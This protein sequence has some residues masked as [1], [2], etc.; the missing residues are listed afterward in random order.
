MSDAHDK[1]QELENHLRGGSA[2]SQHYDAAS[3]E[4]PSTELD[5]RIL[6]A[7]RRAVRAGPAPLPV[8]KKPMRWPIPLATAAIVVLSATVILRLAEQV[9]QPPVATSNVAP[10]AVEARR[11]AEQI[12]PAAGMDDRKNRLD[13]K[14]PRLQEEKKTVVTVPAAPPQN[15]AGSL[16]Q[17][18]RDQSPSKD[19][20]P[21]QQ[22]RQELFKEFNAPTVKQ[23]MEETLPMEESAKMKTE[24][25]AAPASESAKME[26]ER[27][28]SPPPASSLAAPRAV[29]RP[30]T[31]SSE[32][33]VVFKTPELWLEHI[34]E[35]RKAGKLSEAEAGLIQFRKVYPDYALP[36]DLK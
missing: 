9:H 21:A 35:L 18:L 34:R 26:M 36:A 6:A 19:A 24:D 29:A 10:Q 23:G 16:A 27:L 3:T 14:A 7:A 33:P 25:R 12:A 8:R 20:Q 22:P 17:P 1:D 4:T 15:A 11:A 30:Q 13:G 31:S 28:A 2:L 32:E 5:A